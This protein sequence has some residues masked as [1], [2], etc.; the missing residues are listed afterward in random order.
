M[1]FYFATSAKGL[2][3]VLI[4]FYELHKEIQSSTN[5]KLFWSMHQPARPKQPDYIRFSNSIF[6]DC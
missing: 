5:F 2:K 1:P 6:L 3:G 4:L